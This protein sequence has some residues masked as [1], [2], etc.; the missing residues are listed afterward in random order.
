MADSILNL[1]KTEANGLLSKIQIGGKIYEVKDLIA[2]E[3]IDSL[4]AL[5]LELSGNHT[6]DIERIDAAIEAIQKAA[7]DDTALRA[8]ITD[9]QNN[10][11]DKTQVAADI[12]AAVD[13]E[14]AIARAAEKKNADDIT[15]INAVLN[16]VDN[17]DTI[18][19]L[20]ELAIWV[21]EHGADA[22][23]MSAAIT[24]NAEDIAKE[25]KAREDADKA[26]DER[27]ADVEEMLDGEGSVAT[28]INSAKEAAIEAA[29]EYTDGEI[30]KLGDLAAKN[31]TD[32]NLKALAHKDSATGTV[33]GQTISGVKATG[34]STGSITVELAQSEH[35]M[36]STGK[37][38]PAGNV[39]GT[40]SA[41]SYLAVTA[42][43]P[44]V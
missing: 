9:L 5:L 36:S 38:T 35:D 33:A 3:N 34:T 22:A 43:E 20:K 19:S 37:Y 24:K 12:K 44:A 41:A 1:K 30:D 32:L 39:T 15:A 8:L 6:A 42:I 14:A 11:A 26:L 13:A 21:E 29:N 16:T 25:A 4:R 17:E 31:E 2:R 7:Y 40:A 10:K 18:T 27:L 23:E 28:Q